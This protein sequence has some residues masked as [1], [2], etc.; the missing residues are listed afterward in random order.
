MTT[1]G[2]AHLPAAEA[3]AVLREV[4]EGTRSAQPAGAQ[5]A[6]ISVAV[7]E[8]TVL[9]GDVEIVFFINN[10]SLDYI[11]RMRGPHERQAGFTDWLARDGSNPLDLL[12][13]D[14][15]LALETRLRNAD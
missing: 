2:A 9:A 10:A 11:S 3:A 1:P 8:W 6:L 13:E 14:E 7:G 4:L 15:R 12:D 5:R